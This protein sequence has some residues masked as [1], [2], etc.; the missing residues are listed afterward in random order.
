MDVSNLKSKVFI[1]ILYFLKLKEQEDG[2]FS[3]VS[4]LWAWHMRNHG[5]IPSRAKRTISSS[6]HTDQEWELP[7]LNFNGY[8]GFFPCKYIK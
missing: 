8:R 1:S 7:S 3:I 6:K 4:R 2:T 5:L